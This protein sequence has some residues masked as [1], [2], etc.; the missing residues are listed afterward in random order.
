MPNFSVQYLKRAHKASIFHYAE[1]LRSELCVCFHCLA[2]F[3]P[4]EIEIWT[5]ED[6]PRGKTAMCPECGVDA[7]LSSLSGYPINE[8][9]FLKEMN[10]YFFS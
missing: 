7:V 9:E 4:T 3:T 10:R 8:R 5:D 6:D 1:V 2:K